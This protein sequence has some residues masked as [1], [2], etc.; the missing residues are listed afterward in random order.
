MPWQKERHR[1]SA[2]RR[3]AGYFQ[4]IQENV[5][6]CCPAPIPDS[7][8]QKGLPQKRG[9]PVLKRHRE[10]SG[11]LVAAVEFINTTGGID[12]FLLSGEERMAFGAN[13]DLG[14]RTGGFDV[15]N[16]AAG[17]GNDRVFVLGMNIFFHFKQYS[18]YIF[19]LRKI[20]IKTIIY[21]QFT[22]F[23]VQ[24][25]DNLAVKR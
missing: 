12:K 1:A 5:F 22:F 4:L 13:G 25:L 14:F 21:H 18:V 23:Q 19:C 2:G 24:C 9:R 6:C 16:F 11:L 7:T 20:H 10:G 17:A 15:P 3:C 8:I